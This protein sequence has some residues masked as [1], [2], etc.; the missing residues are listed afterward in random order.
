MFTPDYRNILDSAYNRE[1]AR[2]PLYEHVISIEKTEP[3]TEEE[4]TPAE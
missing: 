3:E 4:E 2:L 1:A